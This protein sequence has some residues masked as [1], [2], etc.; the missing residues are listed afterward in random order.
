[1]VEQQ[2]VVTENFVFLWNGEIFNGIDVPHKTSD[3]RIL[4][5]RLSN[6]T[7]AFIDTLLDV[8]G[9]VQGPFAFV[10]YRKFENEL[11]FG[12]DLFGRR[13][14]LW[15][16]PS[17]ESPDFA[18]SSVALF[19]KESFAEVPVGSVHK[20]SLEKLFSGQENYITEYKFLP[21]LQDRRTLTFGADDIDSCFHK[22]LL[23]AVRRRVF[24]IDSVS[25]DG[26]RVAL[27]FSGGLDSSVL[28]ALADACIP[29]NFTIELINVAFENSRFIRTQ[30]LKD[31]QFF[32][33]V[34]DRE[35]G[36]KSLDDLR[37]R[38]PSR[39]W[40]FVEINVSSGLFQEHRQKIID[41]M[42][43]NDTV[44]DL[45]IASAFYFCSR[46]IGLVDGVE[47]HCQSKVLIVGFGADELLGGYSRYR[48]KFERFGEESLKEEMQLDFER[49]WRRNL[50]RDDRILSVFGREPRYP[51]LDEEFVS[52]V[53][54]LPVTDCLVDF[55]LPRGAGEKLILRNLAVKLQLPYCASLAKRAIQFGAKT[56]KMTEGEHTGTLK[57]S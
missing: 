51:F 32:D 47:Y 41:L 35:S 12:R 42:Y 38:S 15:K 36:L 24:N 8:F 31:H 1:M 2:P 40:V 13:S 34:P 29:P 3:T 6:S 4:V 19:P 52:F 11:Y 37:R 43:P 5:Q 46:G 30:K 18:L 21:M 39:R 7:L 48:S 10:I 25:P 20:L 53:R 45:S 17:R 26:A 54:S 14:L 27:L 33:N 57:I 23:N 16:W 22:L 44:M 50:G 49:I 28:A 9:S 56:A 55:T